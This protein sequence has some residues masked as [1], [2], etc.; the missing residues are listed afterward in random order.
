MSS[1][2]RVF[3]QQ[4]AKAFLKN[5]FACHHIA[6]AYLFSGAQGLGKISLAVNFAQAVLCQE[7]QPPF[8]ECHCEVCRKVAA[9]IHPDVKIFAE[10]ETERSIKIELIRNL[11]SEIMLRPLE[12]AKKVFIL[13]NAERMTEEA[14]NAFLKTLE[15]P[16]A[17]THIV[18]TCSDV[19]RLPVTIISRLMQVRLIPLEFAEVERIL[20]DEFELTEGASFFAHLSQGSPGLAYKYYEEGYLEKRDEI[21][22]GLV[23]DEVVFFQGLAGRKPAEIEDVLSLSQLILHDAYL[24]QNGVE[25]DCWAN[26]DRTE[27]IEKI[28]GGCN[29][30]ALLEL[31][32]LIEDSRS[33]IRRNVNSKLMLLRLSAKTDMLIGC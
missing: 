28:A 25:S 13:K 7:G 18:L 12:G 5:A 9:G 21:L 29:S 22:S 4:K 3:G 8:E 27:D 30:D 23:Q 26:Q 10:D 24:A 15:E 19:F 20:R 14:A 11:Q 31:I 6:G 17:D 33:G 1:L 32:K 16:P 2:H